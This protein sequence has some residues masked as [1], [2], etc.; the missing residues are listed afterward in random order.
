MILT[1]HT[2]GGA[3]G[4]PGP[5]AVGVVLTCG[6][7]EV[8]HGRCIGDTTNNV[9]EYTAVLEALSRIPD[10]CLHYQIEKIEFYLDSELVVKQLKGEYRVKDAALQD[11]NRKVRIG[12]GEL[13]V[14]VSFQHVPRSQNAAADALVN[15]ALDRIS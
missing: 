10:L 13:S 15:Q 6:T 5:A 14:P 4:N 1:V 3:R 8:R 2:D 9:A 7:D 12:L 11:L